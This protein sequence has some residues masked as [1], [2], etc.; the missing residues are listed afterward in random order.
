MQTQQYAQFTDYPKLFKKCCWGGDDTSP[1]PAPCIVANRNAFVS[2]YG[3]TKYMG[4]DNPK[5]DLGMFDHCELYQCENGYVFIISP[6]DATPDLDACAI[7][8]ELTKY[9]KL[10]SATATT[11]IKTFRNKREFNLYRKR[12]A[13]VEPPTPT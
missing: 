7:R 2:D 12:V 8:H 1:P 3:V 10:Y 13:K 4:N 9:K 11:Y 5:S 6:N